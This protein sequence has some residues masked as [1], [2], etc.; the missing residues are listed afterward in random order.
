MDINDQE[1]FEQA[2]DDGATEQV[3]EQAGTSETGTGEEAG[4]ARDEQGRFAAKQQTEQ[5]QQQAPEGQAA[6][7]AADG[8]DAHVP[9]WRMRELREER[10]AALRQSQ[11]TEQRLMRQI[12]ELQSRMPKQE[13]QQVPDVFE[14]PNRFLEHG[15]SQAVNP[16]KTEMVQLREF[17]SRREAVREFGQEKVDAAY[18]A[19]AAGMQSR[20]PEVVTT[21]QR[22]MQSMDPFGEIVR[23]HQQ[24]TVFQQIGGNPDAWFEKQLEERM[25]DAAFAGS[26]LSKIQGNAAGQQAGGSR[27]T[28]KIPPSLNK[29]ASAQGAT[30]DDNDMSDEALFAHAMR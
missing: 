20:D 11:D 9:S 27:P 19:I 30:A 1:L 26:L 22:A 23:W 25:K 21:Y 3:T 6:Q 14:D 5:V 28:I 24:K 17:Y 29:V 16:I 4:Q 12:A 2:L 10:D 8:D 13:P 18:Q 15:V 7:T